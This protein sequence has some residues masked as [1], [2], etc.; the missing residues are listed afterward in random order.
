MCAYAH[1]KKTPP[2]LQ[3]HTLIAVI[4]SG[5]SFNLQGEMQ[6]EP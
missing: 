6:A 5:L 1:I 3:H 2:P 4:L